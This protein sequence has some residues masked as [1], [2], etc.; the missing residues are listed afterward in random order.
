MADP[1]KPA[2]V[3]ETE[4]MITNDEDTQNTV[5]NPFG[6]TA[7]SLGGLMQN[8]QVLAALQN[9]LGSM[10]G[11]QSGYIESLPK[12][13]KRRIKALKKLQFEVIKIESKFY[14]E[15]H[16][17]ECKYAEQFAPLYDRR[18]EIGKHVVESCIT[19]A[20]AQHTKAVPQQY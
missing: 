13:V 16:D 17:L 11:V 7:P 9:Q 6:I 8:P 2:V 1:D 10:V 20:H 3:E 15:V 4:K 14:E 18:R 5:A 19:C 12:V